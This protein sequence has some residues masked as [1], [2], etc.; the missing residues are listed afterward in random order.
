MELKKI[1]TRTNWAVEDTLPWIHS[2]QHIERLARAAGL[3]P[4][5]YSFDSVSLGNGQIE[6]TISG[7]PA[8]LEILA[9]E[10]NE[11][12]KRYGW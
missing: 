9:K 2:Q 6:R 7:S 8:L 12:A 1:G 4:E 3:G 5:H 10:M 11:R